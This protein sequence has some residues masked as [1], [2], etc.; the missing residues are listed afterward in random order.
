MGSLSF[1]CFQDMPQIFMK[2]KIFCNKPKWWSVSHSCWMIWVFFYFKGHFV[3]YSAT[4]CHLGWVDLFF[5]FLSLRTFLEKK[6]QEIPLEESWRQGATW[7]EKRIMGRV[8]PPRGNDPWEEYLVGPGTTQSLVV[9]QR[10]KNHF[11][12]NVLICNL[13]DKIK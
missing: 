7:D 8:H 1:S 10:K 2:W 12:T 13:R 4:M 3:A 11:C 9:N 6:K 5:P